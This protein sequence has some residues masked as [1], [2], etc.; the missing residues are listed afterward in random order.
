M[1]SDSPLW[2]KGRGRRF[3]TVATLLAGVVSACLFASR[4]RAE[5]AETSEVR[6]LLTE[7]VSEYDA[8]RYEEARALFRRVNQ[9]A[10]SARALRGIGM[11]SFEL[12]D[13]VQA[14]Q[15]LEGAL[16]ETRRALTPEQRR[17][18][19]RLIERTNA[20]LGRFVITL[21]PPNA[22]LRIDGQTAGITSG[23]T[24][25]LGFG[26]HTLTAEAPR[27]NSLTRELTVMGGERQDLTFALN[28][29][30]QSQSSASAATASPAT[31]ESSTLPDAG[32]VAASGDQR[33]NSMPW[34]VGAGVLGAGAVAT[35]IWGFQLSGELERCRDAGD[36]C[37]NEDTLTGRRNLAIGLT[38]GLA[39]GAV[40][41]TVVGA[42]VG[43]RK[44][45]AS[46]GTT[47][48]CAPGLGTVHCALTF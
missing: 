16:A 42:V 40:A 2:V 21:S 47:V 18:V 1:T 19:E 35:G 11:A 25:M 31:G 28:L 27:H 20:Y 5:E 38:V 44:P 13:Y 10:P 23:N 4:A 14:L 17:H 24:V 34:F 6:A 43:S 8:G 15:S 29:A 45:Q 22:I 48:A 30:P 33:F 26:P 32:V 37:L 41:L 12:R 36:L 9:V 46:P 3:A 39:A 7:A